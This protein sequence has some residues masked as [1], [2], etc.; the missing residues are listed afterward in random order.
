MATKGSCLNIMT[1]GSSIW[2]MT[3][4][5][6][7]KA[8]YLPFLYYTSAGLQWITSCNLRSGC[9]PEKQ[10][11]L[12]PQDARRLNNGY[13]VLKFMNMH[14]WFQQSSKIH[15]VGLI[16]LTGLSG[17]SMRLVWCILYLLE[18]LL[19]RHICWKRMP[20]LIELIV[21]GLLIIMWI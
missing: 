12:F 13:Y 9:L 10:Y 4:I 18:Q 20:H 17:L 7:S 3:L 1:S 15:I 14:W 16:V 21:Y 11:W 8:K 5:T 6:P 19:D 2:N